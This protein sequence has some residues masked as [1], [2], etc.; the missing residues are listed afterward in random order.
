MYK[1]L[2]IF[3]F[4]KNKKLVLKMMIFENRKK[5]RSEKHKHYEIY[6]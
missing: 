6:N 3:Q 2:F 4:I 5:I 1:F